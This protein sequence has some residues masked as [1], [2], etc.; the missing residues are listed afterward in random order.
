M[1]ASGE[2]SHHLAASEALRFLQGWFAHCPTGQLLELRPLHR[3]GKPLP[4][5][6]GASAGEAFDAVGECVRHGDDVYLGALP[7]LRRG[8][9]A[10]DVGGRVWLW[11]D[12]DYGTVGHAKPAPYASREEA[13]AAIDAVGIAP[14]LLNDTGGGFHPWYALDAEASASEWC[15]AITALAFALSADPNALDPPRILRVAGTL[16]FKVEPSRQVRLLR[17][18]DAAHSIARFLALRRESSPSLDVRAGAPKGPPPVA[19]GTDRPFGRGNAI[20]IA[21]VLTWLG[22]KTHTEGPRTYCACPVHHGTNPSQMVVGGSSN[23]AFCFGDCQRSFTPVDLVAAARGV[24]PREAVNLLADRFGFEGFVSTSAPV[25]SRRNGAAKATAPAESAPAVEDATTPTEPPPDEPPPAP[26]RLRPP[27]ARGDQLEV[28]HLTLSVLRSQGKVTFDEGD[29]YQYETATGIWQRLEVE[30][31]AFVAASFAGSKIGVKHPRPLLINDGALRGIVNVARMLLLNEAGRPV[32]TRPWRGV[33]FRNGFVEVTGG[34]LALRAHAEDHMCRYAYPFDF[35]AHAATARL[36]SFLRELF[37]DVQ[38]R[39]EA[40][41]RKALLQEFAGAC[42]TGLATTYQKL[43]VLYGTGNN[44]KSELLRLLRALFP[45]STVASL[46]PQE[47]GERF[48]VARL[49]GVLAN[50]V[51]E[52]PE[53]DIATGEVFKGVITGD[54]VSTERK[55]RDPFEF[56]PVAG[57]IFS[58][59]SLP[60]TVDQ[61]DGYWRRFA[62]CPFT[63]D[64]TTAKSRKNDAAREVIEHEL[65]GLAVW[66]LRGAARLQ[67][68]GAYSTTPDAAAVLADWRDEADPVRRF[69]LERRDPPGRDYP[70]ASLYEFWKVWARENGFADMSSTRF[71]RRV[72]ATGLYKRERERAGRV[73]VRQSA[74]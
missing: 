24:I 59:N 25:D 14:T 38:T 47:W 29:F 20:P 45:P 68:V 39:E 64:F 37:G 51:D 3:G 57:H 23:S 6:G 2:A 1:T 48:K 12:I 63:R 49:V 50:F 22:A 72:V 16:N 31:V 42:L 53:R 46:P 33:A 56:H 73:Y 44:G 4:R 13:L 19:R 17:A 41:G 11:G 52:I 62:I 8:G 43:L 32:F 34:Q 65:P 27:L 18:T 66:A 5:P 71:G 58:A 70:A 7:R 60:G 67:L 26:F 36:D 74:P 55:N 35:N 21:D 30:Q 15:D 54:P 10:A 28:A 61:S 40:D 9:R 69:L